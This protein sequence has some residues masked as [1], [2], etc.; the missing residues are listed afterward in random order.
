MDCIYYIEI[1]YILGCI[2]PSYLHRIYDRCSTTGEVN[3]HIKC[4]RTILKNRSQDMDVVQKKSK[5][6]YMKNKLVKKL[7]EVE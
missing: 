5:R 6:F 7:T 2:V 1:K 4:M 3:H